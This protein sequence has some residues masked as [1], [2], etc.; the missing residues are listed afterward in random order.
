MR[1]EG[2]VGRMNFPIAF[3]TLTPFVRRNEV[4]QF[5]GAIAD[6]C[7]AF[8]AMS[9]PEL[10][11]IWGSLLGPEWSTAHVLTLRERYEVDVSDG[12]KLHSAAAVGA[13]A[14]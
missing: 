6:D 8:I 14:T 11:R 10:W 2:D 3:F 4:R 13:R 9:Y 12:G 7:P 5:A 1:Q